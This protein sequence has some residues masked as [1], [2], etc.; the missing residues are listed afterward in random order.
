[1]NG[2]Y[3]DADRTRFY[4][5]LE[6]L[7]KSVDESKKVVY[8]I[9]ATYKD[10][11]ILSKKLNIEIVKTTSSRRGWLLLVPIPISKNFIIKLKKKEDLIDTIKALE[12][13]DPIEVFIFDKNLEENFLRNFDIGNRE[14]TRD[15]ITKDPE[16]LIYGMDF[17]NA[18]STTEAIEFISYGNDIPHKMKWFF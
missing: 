14:Y 9:G 5:I 16:Y 17:D 12:D 15:I 6:Y 1:M 13:H 8:L 18:E 2:I 11:G 3:R 4:R 7:E 10:I